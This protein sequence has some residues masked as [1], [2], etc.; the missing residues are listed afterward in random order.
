MTESDEERRAITFYTARRFIMFNPAPRFFF[1]TL[2][3]ARQN[4]EA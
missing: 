4:C 3:A 2:L 1:G